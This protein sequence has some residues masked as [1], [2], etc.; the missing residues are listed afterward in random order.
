MDTAADSDAESNQC[1]A[2]IQKARQD[3]ETFLKTPTTILPEFPNTMTQLSL[4]NTQIPE[5]A[6]RTLEIAEVLGKMYM[7]GALADI[8]TTMFAEDGGVVGCASWVRDVLISESTRAAI[9]T[10]FNWT[11]AKIEKAHIIYHMMAGLHDSETIERGEEDME[12]WAGEFF[13]QLARVANKTRQPD[14]KG[15]YV[16]SP[17]LVHVANNTKNDKRPLAVVQ[18]EDYLR[19]QREGEQIPMVPGWIEEHEVVKQLLKDDV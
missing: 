7:M 15:I 6:L 16:L 14:T 13:R 12:R 19:R 10:R 17:A 11:S 1:K 4:D 2:F 9:A 18:M 3:V 8:L 5:T